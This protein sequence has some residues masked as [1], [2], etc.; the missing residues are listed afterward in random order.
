MQFKSTQSYNQQMARLRRAKKESIITLVRHNE[1][2][3]FKMGRWNTVA[4]TIYADGKAVFY[5][6]V[7][8][9]QAQ[10]V[11]A[12]MVRIGFDITV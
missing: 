7:S 4:I 9:A 5:N 3:T 8:C 1:S 10:V 2:V 6:I 12:A 11:R